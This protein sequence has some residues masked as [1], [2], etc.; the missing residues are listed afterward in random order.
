MKP[1]WLLVGRVLATWGLR[2]AVKI[3]NLSDNPERWE[4]GRR[5]YLEDSSEP[6]EIV[7]AKTVGRS[8]VVEFQGYGSPEAAAPL[9]GRYLRIPLAEAKKSGENYF[10]YEI[11]GLEV[12][13][14]DGDLLGKVTEILETGSNDVY[15][16]KGDCGEALIPAIK[17]VVKSID[18]QS[19]KM[20]VKL[21]EEE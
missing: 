15:V 21:L 9:L 10:W 18:L 12:W 20:I 6:L 5:V 3:E 16:V 1:E 19:G 13:T 14:T 7:S 2:G 4:K 17:E 11:V 8:L